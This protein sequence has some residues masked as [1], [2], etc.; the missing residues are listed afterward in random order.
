M[1]TPIYSQEQLD[2]AVLKNSQEGVLRELSV[3]REEI[4]SESHKNTNLILGIYAMIG[5]AALGKLFGII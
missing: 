5:A 3:I 4:K 2:I 1:S